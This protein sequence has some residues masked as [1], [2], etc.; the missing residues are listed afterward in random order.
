MRPTTT[1][2]EPPLVFS[3]CIQLPLA[4]QARRISMTVDLSQEN[5]VSD[6]ADRVLLCSRQG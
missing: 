2:E 4:R 1:W 3:T 6:R 5:P